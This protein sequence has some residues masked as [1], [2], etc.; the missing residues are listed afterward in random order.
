MRRHVWAR[1]EVAHPEE[2][3]NIIIRYS[4]TTFFIS[5]RLISVQ[6]FWN[7]LQYARVISPVAG[8]QR[9]D[10]ER[11]RFTPFPFPGNS[12]AVP[13]D[14]DA[15]LRTLQIVEML[16]AVKRFESFYHK[17]LTMGL[18]YIQ[19]TFIIVACSQQNAGYLKL[20]GKHFIYIIRFHE[21]FR[22]IVHNHNA[23]S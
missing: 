8:S 17:Y 3:L 13:S 6:L 23:L 7:I 14:F 10:F 5:T 22:L 20:L 12:R 15:P 4:Y 1:T 19:I 2:R 18:I 21:L 16:I 11:C 9:G